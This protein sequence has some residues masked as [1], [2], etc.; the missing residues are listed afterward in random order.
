MFGDTLVLNLQFTNDLARLKALCR[1]GG[2]EFSSG[3]DHDLQTRQ[4]QAEQS[5]QALKSVLVA[6]KATK[7]LS[8]NGLCG[9]P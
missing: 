6:Y 1:S 5:A 3:P 2:E 4:S 7:N 8:E 9:T